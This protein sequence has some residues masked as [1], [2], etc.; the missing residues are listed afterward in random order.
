MTY[1]YADGKSDAD[2]VSYN[3]VRGADVKVIM[4]ALQE[5]NPISQLHE[6]FGV[7]G[8]KGRETKA[9]DGALK[10]LQ[11]TDF[12]ERPSERTVEPM[13][14]QPFEHLSFELRMCHHLNQQKEPQDHFIKLH[15][16]LVSQDAGFVD[17]DEFEE[18][19]QRELGGY[20]FDWN[21][22]KVKMWY[23]LM[24][25][26]GLVSVR[27]NQD[28]LTSPSPAMFYDAL[29][30]FIDAEGSSRIRDALNWIEEN[31]FYCYANRGGA[32]PRVHTGLD[33][34][35]ETMTNDGV[36]ELSATSDSTHE[37]AVP[38]ETAART[39]TFSLN[40]RPDAPAYKYPLESHDL[41]V[42][43]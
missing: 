43:L 6:D 39:S 31:F 18:E 24:S 7:P 3:S 19:L 17:K 37:V 26:L 5:S 8:E 35:I 32:A 9:V 42:S 41:E 16:L 34:T 20:P 22:Q 28:I 15:Q 36:L 2:L 10:F 14:G 27:N 25:P 40:E 38:S 13:T 1:T 21:K 12:V 29:D 33:Q 11:A 30:A 23:D 4:D